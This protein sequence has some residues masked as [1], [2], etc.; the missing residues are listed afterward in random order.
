MSELAGAAIRTKLRDPR[1]LDL[2]MA[3]VAA[4]RNVGAQRWYDAHFARRFAVARHYLGLVRP[5]ALAGFVQAFDLLLPPAGFAPVMVDDLFDATTRQQLRDTVRT[6]PPAT[7]KSHEMADFGRHIVHDFPWFVELQQQLLPRMSALA[8]RE[9][10]CGYNFLSLYRGGGKCDPHM[11]QPK[12]MFTLDYCI[13]QSEDWPIWF[14]RVCDWP[15]ADIMH[16]WHPEAIK[17][18]PALE[19]RPYRIEPDKALLFC[20]SSQWHYRDP[21]SPGG[22]CSL[23]FFH[24]F[25]KGAEELVRPV[26]WAQHFDIPELEPLCDLFR[27]EFA[28]AG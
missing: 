9:L 20:G 23:L 17:A 5:D 28:E 4:I 2:H 18:D 16:S 22:F 25:P 7:L 8:G 24:Y 15:T 13:E 3:A 6:M 12:S 27:E 10:V 14:S 26:L 1:Y 21:I 19:F 11:D